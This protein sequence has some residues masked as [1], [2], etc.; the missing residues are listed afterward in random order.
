MII[1]DYADIL[2]TLDMTVSIAPAASAME[3]DG[4]YEDVMNDIHIE[5]FNKRIIT[6]IF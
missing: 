4:G 6:N 3:S 2:N 1:D 5:E